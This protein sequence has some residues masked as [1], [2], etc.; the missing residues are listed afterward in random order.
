[1]KKTLRFRCELV[2]EATKVKLTLLAQT[3]YGN[4]FGEDYANRFG[5]EGYMEIISQGTY[6]DTCYVKLGALFVPAHPE[7]ITGVE[8]KYLIT[9]EELEN[10]KKVVLAYTSFEFRR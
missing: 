8:A 9:L 1:M 10:I 6:L 5:K 7:R 3:H 2:N 4:S